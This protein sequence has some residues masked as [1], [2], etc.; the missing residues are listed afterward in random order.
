MTAKSPRPASAGR[1]RGPQRPPAGKPVRP[2]QA[3][4]GK[5]GPRLG[6]E[7][8]ED[9][10][11]A[12]SHRGTWVVVGIAGVCLL[13]GGALALGMRLGSSSTPA[14][15]ESAPAASGAP[16]SESDSGVVTPDQPVVIP[17]LSKNPDAQSAAQKASGGLAEV[18]TGQLAWHRTTLNQPEFTA[19]QAINEVISGEGIY[20]EVPTGLQIDEDGNVLATFPFRGADGKSAPVDAGVLLCFSQPM[21]SWVGSPAVPGGSIADCSALLATAKPT[22]AASG[23]ATSSA[24]PGAGS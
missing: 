22:P 9:A 17:D 21:Q 12:S 15:G 11:V 16:S 24:A 18:A 8:V 3:R 1:P 23:V 6:S 4:T 19:A 5:P 2:P 10:P 14:A 20:G 13:V 7:R